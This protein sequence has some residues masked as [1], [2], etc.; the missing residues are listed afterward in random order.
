MLNH[1]EWLIQGYKLQ[2]DL[3]FILLL[4]GCGTRF[5]HKNNRAFI[6]FSLGSEH[7]SVR[8]KFYGEVCL[9]H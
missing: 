4:N 5:V 3:L 2:Y 1:F 8:M 9:H 6:Y 7:I